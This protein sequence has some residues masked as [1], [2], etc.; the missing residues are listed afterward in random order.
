M[1]IE[2]NDQLGYTIA[3]MFGVI[4]ML[5][6]IIVV[7]M[8]V[9]AKRYQMLKFESK[10][11]KTVEMDM[12]FFKNKVNDYNTALKTMEIHV[13]NLNKRLSELGHA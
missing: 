1:H 13:L 11:L 2:I 3:V 8:G 6:V 5:M 12:E 10:R 7:F 4:V 9:D